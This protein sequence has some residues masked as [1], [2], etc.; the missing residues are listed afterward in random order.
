MQGCSFVVAHEPMPCP[1]P[2]ITV[3]GRFAHA[4]YPTEYKQWKNEAQDLIEA[5]MDAQ[6]INTYYDVPLQVILVC[7][8]QKPKTSK[9]LAPKPDVDNYA[10]AIMD[11]LTAAGAWG[12]DA[13]VIDLRV[14]KRWTNK[15]EK[16]HF[17]VTIN[18]VDASDPWQLR[19]V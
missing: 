4:Y 7:V 14:V 15:G 19:G 3:R 8:V 16:P 9:L 13:Q 12:D 1:R 17:T 11:A 5:Q 2:R 10:K 6:P 18:P